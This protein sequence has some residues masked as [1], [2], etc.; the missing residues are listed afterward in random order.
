MGDAVEAHKYA[1]ESAKVLHRDVS[2]GNI[3]LIAEEA[4]LIDW[5][6]SKD[7]DRLKNQRR[8]R[9]RTG[10]WQF[11]S[12]AIL[13]NPKLPQERKDDI[14]SFLHVTSHTA[15]AYTPSAMTPDTRGNH[16]RD[17]FDEMKQESGHVVGGAWKATTLIAD[18]YIPETF[19]TTSPLG[20]LLRTLSKTIGVRYRTPPTVQEREDD[21]GVLAE[22]NPARVPKLLV[23]LRSFNYDADCKKIETS[24]WLLETLRAAVADRTKWPEADRAARQPIAGEVLLT[25]KQQS[26][27]STYLSNR[28]SAQARSYHPT[29][30]TSAS[31]KRRLIA[32]SGDEETKPQKVARHS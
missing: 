25:K 27:Y 2:A 8:R 31:S 4:L 10:T 13:Q 18:R 1:Y 3:I 15:I 23:S 5:D 6:L 29:P 28:D 32:G 26:S 14:E 24:D 11:M 22:A 9:D 7:I 21:A 16:L 17:V 12:A 20:E 19:Q 30:N